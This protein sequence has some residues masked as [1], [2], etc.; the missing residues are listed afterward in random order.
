MKIL[1]Y[2]SKKHRQQFP[3]F[4]A[5]LP[6]STIITIS[7]SHREFWPWLNAS[8]IDAVMLSR[9]GRSKKSH[10]RRLV[11][12]S[13]EVYIVGKSKMGQYIKEA[14]EGWQERQLKRGPFGPY[15]AATLYSVLKPK[16]TK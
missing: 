4:V 3:G 9:D 14:C 2:L 7:G 11:R 6:A 16:E 12:L 13:D 5:A 15:D 8:G 10:A 1:L